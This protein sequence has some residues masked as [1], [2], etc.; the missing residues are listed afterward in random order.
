MDRKCAV[1]DFRQELTTL[2]LGRESLW[3]VVAQAME[4]LLGGAGGVYGLRPA[5]ESGVGLAFCEG[6]GMESSR[7]GRTVRGFLSSGVIT[8]DPLLVPPAHRNRV[9]RLTDLERAGHLSTGRRAI[10]EEDAKHELGSRIT[11][12]LRL[13]VCDGATALA[14]VG[15]L[16][17]DADFSFS[18]R[19]VRTLR[20]LAPAII[21]RVVL[22][23]RLGK[24]ALASAALDAVLSAVEHPTW[25]VNARGDVVLC[26]GPGRAHLGGRG[27]GVLMRLREVARGTPDPAFRSVVVESSGLPRHT[28]VMG[29]G[30]GGE[31]GARLR[32]RA[33]E[34]SLTPREGQ[35][36]TL[37]ARGLPNHSVARELGCSLRAVEAHVTTVMRKARVDNRASLVA[38]VWTS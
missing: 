35:I 2:R 17:F 6:S 7:L 14:W 5:A 11:D 23:E 10:F 36:L 15:A 13:L 8:Y 16:S 18:S 12:Q 21:E 31:A 26:N 20:A 27:S 30:E 25:L 29:R 33:T 3:V 24:E 38:R 34:W 37:V 9:T 19:A 28:L 4:G 1:E 22:Q 32:D